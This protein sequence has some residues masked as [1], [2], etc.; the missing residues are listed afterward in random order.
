MRLHFACRNGRTD[1]CGDYGTVSVFDSRHEECCHQLL[2]VHDRK[3]LFL[4]I[5]LATAMVAQFED[6][7]QTVTPTNHHS[8]ARHSLSH[9]ALI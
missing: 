5:Q 4:R 3:R 8:A 6:D 1:S 9:F 7:V 2:T